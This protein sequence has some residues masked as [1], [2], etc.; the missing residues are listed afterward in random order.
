MKQALVLFSGTGSVCQTLRQLNYSVT[1]LGDGSGFVKKKLESLGT[2][3]ADILTWN[4]THYDKK[5]FSVVWASPPCRHYSCL[6]KCFRPH[7]DLEQT[8][9]KGDKYV[10][11]ALEIIYY[12]EKCHWFIENPMTSALRNRPFMQSFV[13]INVDYCQFA[14]EWGYQK[15]T[16]IFHNGP[17]RKDVRCNRKTCEACITSGKTG[18]RIQKR[19]QTQGKNGQRRIAGKAL[20]R[21]PEKL[22]TYLGKGNY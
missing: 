4:Y 17:K 18:R 8:Y 21:V 14:P 16:R 1:S 13:Y 20:Y 10:L 7:D 5:H 11:K 2:I 9:K 12:F 15:P 6:L 22:I 3:V 19:R